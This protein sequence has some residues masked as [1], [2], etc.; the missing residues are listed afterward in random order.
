MGNKK[1]VVS[2][3][4]RPNVGKSSLFNRIIGKRVAVVD[5]IAGVT[6][7]RHYFTANWN[8]HEFILIDTGGMLPSSREKMAEAIHE[9]VHI[10]VKESNLVLFLVDAKSGITDL[11][12]LIAKQLRK[13]AS[14]KTIL[15]V[16]KADSRKV[17]YEIN[18][19]RALGIDSIYPVSAL[20]GL[21]VADLLDVVIERISGSLAPPE[22]SL[23]PVLR[24]AI[25]GRPN[26]GK[27]SLVNK[28]LGKNRMI[29]H[30]EPGTT[31]DAI[32]TELLYKDKR[33]VL[34]DTA[35]LRKRSHVKEDMEYYSNLRAI[36]SIERC[37][38]CVLVVDVKNRIGVQDLRIVK[39]IQE[40]RKGMLLAW[41]KWDIVE[42]DHKTFDQLVAA[43]REEFMELRYIPMV[44]ISALTGQRVTTVID[45]A[46]EIKERLKTRVPSAEF[47]NRVFSWVRSH[48]HPA[49]PENP[50]RFL[51]AKQV[52]A[53]YPVFKFFVT[54]P[55]QISP[56]Y[57][58][59]LS[60]KIYETY[61][62]EGCP[63]T[64]EFRPIAKAKHRGSAGQSE[65]REEV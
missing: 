40:M 14:E 29:V 25:V 18:T 3:I 46:L 44:S 9:Q 47:E 54:N 23:E 39:K 56:A 32:D 38:I 37:D 58:R 10:A 20:H 11:D 61:N 36:Q 52:D 53:P 64:L 48:P 41:N 45:T 28:L 19:Y 35:G 24:L 4:G 60:N 51:G 31:R 17:E 55:K 6:R 13:D 42:K 1:P 26:A 2:V 62:F 21:G 65:N 49:I 8:G 5:D 16:N 30:H 15:V 43:T 63:L 59:Y 12:M 33:I 34:I 7:D 50:V 27:S 57:I 22:E